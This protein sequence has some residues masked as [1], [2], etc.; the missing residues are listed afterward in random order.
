MLELVSIGDML[1]IPLGRPCKEARKIRNPIKIF[2]RTLSLG[3]KELHTS[4]ALFHSRALS[5]FPVGYLLDGCSAPSY[6]TCTL[7]QV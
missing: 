3:L 7:S 6:A 1:K 5:L 4:H 2:S